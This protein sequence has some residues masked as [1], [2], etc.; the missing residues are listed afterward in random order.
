MAN[1]DKKDVA[2]L[3][4]LASALVQMCSL[5]VKTQFGERVKKQAE[6][7]A[8]ILVA[9]G[10]LAPERRSE[11]VKKLVFSKLAA[12]DGLQKLASAATTID[13]RLGVPH[14]SPARKEASAK[15]V[16]DEGIRRLM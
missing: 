15:E 16:W 14:S 3:C 6:K 10:N 7:T 5:L 13:T 2:T 9:S 8:D 11:A 1:I 4:K 12:F